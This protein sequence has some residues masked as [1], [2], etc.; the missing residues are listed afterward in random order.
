MVL[1]GLVAGV[2]IL[3]IAVWVFAVL[4][5]KN[6][7][8]RHKADVI[9]WV[10]ILLFTIPSILGV[11]YEHT[12]PTFAM[13]ALDVVMPI[14]LFPGACGLIWLI[15]RNKLFPNGVRGIESRNAKTIAAFIT[16]FMFITIFGY[17]NARFTSVRWP[18][19]V[20]PSTREAQPP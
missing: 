10:A 4:D 1:F 18:L 8:N 12:A 14:D 13:K 16:L 9:A 19:A 20:Q 3:Y 11:A 5:M 17:V 6:E 2:V 15:Y 7:R